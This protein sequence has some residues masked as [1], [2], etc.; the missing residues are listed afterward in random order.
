MKGEAKR[1]KAE[2]IPS[3]KFACWPKFHESIKN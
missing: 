3:F 1:I 2:V